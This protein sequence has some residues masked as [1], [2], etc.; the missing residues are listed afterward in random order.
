MLVQRLLGLRRDAGP[1]IGQAK[2]V[3]QDQMR[4]PAGVHQREAHR[5]HAAGR[6]AQHSDVPDAEVIQQGRGVRG[7][8]LEA[9]MDIGLG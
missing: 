9:V 3:F 6:V 5:C 2:R 8:Q 7:Q 4:D 1:V